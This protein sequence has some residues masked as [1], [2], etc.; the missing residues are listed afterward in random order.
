[1]LWL[2]YKYH[3]KFSS[4]FGIEEEILLQSYFLKARS[5]PIVNNGHFE[6]DCDLN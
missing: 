1:M 5:R 4:L 2:W 6:A 3:H